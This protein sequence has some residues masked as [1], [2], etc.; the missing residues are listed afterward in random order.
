MSLTPARDAYTVVAIPA[1][2][3]RTGKLSYFTD[4]T[5]IHAADANG[6]PVNEQAPVLE[7]NEVAPAQ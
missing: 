2:Y 3:G 6:M 7:A 5:A 1:R 4:G